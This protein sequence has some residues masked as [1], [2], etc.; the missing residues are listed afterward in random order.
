MAKV[1]TKIVIDMM[2]GNVLEE[3]FYEYFGPVGL[4]KH[5]K[6]QLKLAGEQDQ[7]YENLL[8]A[9]KT[10]FAGQSAV[11]DSLNKAAS[12]IVAQ[13]PS[14]Y[15]YSA[16]QDA[17]LRTQASEGTASEYKSARQATGENLAAVGGGSTF[18]PSG[19]KAAIMSRVNT[20]AAAQESGQQLDI[21]NRG[22]DIGRDQYNRA[23]GTL[24]GVAAAYDPLGFS[25]SAQSAGTKALDTETQFQNDRNAAKAQWMGAIAG[26]ATSFIPGA[27]LAKNL[28]NL[29]KGAV[30]GASSGY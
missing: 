17:A 13:G 18:L 29:G 16:K 3:D 27:G 30:K 20:A 2:T 5:S 24:G 26:A 21:T 6:Q 22:Y 28:M 14:Q 8:G 1:Y 25:S 15:G 19:T 10:R 7:M 4:C 11:L 12:N 9:Y 23:V